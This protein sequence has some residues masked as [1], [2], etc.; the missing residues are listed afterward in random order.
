MILYENGKRV[1]SRGITFIEN[2]VLLIERHKKENGKI[3]HYYT[4][5]GGGVEDD[6][7]YEEAAVR[8]TFEETTVKTKVIS[9]LEREEYDTG[10]VYWHLLEYISGTPK[11]GGEE[12]ERNNS[13]NHYKVVLID[14][15]LIDEL[16][17]LGRGKDILKK[18]MKEVLNDDD[19][20]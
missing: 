19:K 3:L 11:L 13:D 8:E 18:A 10:I 1:V 6:E 5:P 17:I 4:I 12:L 2:Y 9:F 14:K 20:K 7:T 16:N 15:D